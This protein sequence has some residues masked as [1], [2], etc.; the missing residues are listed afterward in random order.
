[1]PKQK[2]KLIPIKKFLELYP[3]WSVQ[4]VNYQK[5]KKCKRPK[6]RFKTEHETSFVELINGDPFIKTI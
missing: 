4:A 6:I 2:S 3:K 5:S 1:M